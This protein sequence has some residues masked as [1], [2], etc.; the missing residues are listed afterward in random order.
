MRDMPPIARRGE[1]AERLADGQTVMASA[2]ADEFGTS[3]DAIRRDL[4]ALASEGLCRRVY[5]GAL[6]I[7][8][9]ARPLIE[10]VS[11]N[12]AAKHALARIAA[13]QVQPGEFVFLDSGS[14]NLELARVLPN[15]LEL[16]VAT[17][18]VD[19]AAILIRRPD[20]QT[21]LVGGLLHPL[22]GGSVDADACKV[23]AQMNIERCFIGVCA[24]STDSGIS[25]FDSSD[26]SFKRVLLASSRERVA[27]ITNDKFTTRAA[28]RITPLAGIQTYVV[29]HDAPL[30]AVGQLE[31]A[32]ALVLKAQAV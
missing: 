11:E 23:V 25:A 17:N 10:R 27:L 8:T 18:S 13:T 21:I 30:H 29:E 6:P 5:G 20:V 4:R 24:I 28:H 3:E 26:A 12:Q 16:T 31:G 15:D 14:T 9:R 22:V 7:T 2:L 19:I 1:I 32:D